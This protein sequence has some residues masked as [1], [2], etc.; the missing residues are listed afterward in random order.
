LLVAPSASGNK[1]ELTYYPHSLFHGCPCELSGYK[2]YYI[3][4]S[5]EFYRLSA[6][7]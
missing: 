5:I 4:I 3:L 1:E 2:G 6:G 7:K